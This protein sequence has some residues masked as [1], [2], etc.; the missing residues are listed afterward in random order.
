LLVIDWS[1]AQA[2]SKRPNVRSMEYPGA[3]AVSRP[4]AE[5]LFPGFPQIAPFD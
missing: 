1:S 4:G 5:R 3:K 2:P